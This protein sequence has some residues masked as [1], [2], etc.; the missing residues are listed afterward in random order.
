M[1]SDSLDTPV[2]AGEEILLLSYYIWY[3]FNLQTV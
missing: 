3:E 1:L 2:V